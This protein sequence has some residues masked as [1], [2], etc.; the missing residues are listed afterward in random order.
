M[1]I[2]LIIGICLYVIAAF[3]GGL[4]ILHFKGKPAGLEI[5]DES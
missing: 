4:F 3:I 1:S 2:F 5:G